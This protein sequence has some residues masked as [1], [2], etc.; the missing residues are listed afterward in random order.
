MFKRYGFAI[1]LILTSISLSQELLIVKDIQIIGLK[2]MT[3]DRILSVLKM[4][5][6]D[7]YTELRLAETVRSDLHRLHKLNLFGLMKVEM[8][9]EDSNIIIKY[10]LEEYPLISEVVYEGNKNLSNKDINK[11]LRVSAGDRLNPVKVQETIN[12]ITDKYIDKGYREAKVESIIEEREAGKAV[13]KFKINEGEKITIHRI[14]IEGNEVISDWDIRTKVLQ[15]KEDRFYNTKTLDQE[16][17]EEDFK[18]IEEAYANKGYLQA[19][20][21]DY[22][23]KDI[24]N[25]HQIDIIIYVHEGKRYKMGE[26]TITG[27]NVIALEEIREMIPLK[28]GDDFSQKKLDEAVQNIVQKYYSKGYIF[29]NIDKIVD[30]DESTGEVRVKVSIDEGSPAKIRQIVITGN[31]TTRD[32]VI[33]REM[34]IYPGNRYRENKVIRSLQRIFNLG[35]FNSINRDILTTQES[36]QVDLVILVEEKPGTAKVNFGAGYS[37]IDGLVGTIDIDWINFDISKLPKFWRCKGAGQRLTFSI[38]IG[39]RT[40]YYNIGFTEPWF[41]GSPV[42]MSI[43]FY[44]TRLDRYTYEEKRLGTSISFGRSLSEYVYGNI[45]Y[46]IE[47]VRVDSDYNVK[48]LPDWIRENLGTNITSSVRLAFERDSRDNTFFATEG[49]DSY[50]SFELA[51][52][53]FGGNINFFKIENATSWYFKTFWKN[54]LAVR[55]S[56]GYVSSYGKTKQ[57]PIFERFYIGGSQTVRGYEDWELGPMDKYGN[58]EGGTVMLYSNLEFRIPIVKNML[59]VLGFWDSGY[60]WKDF[61]SR[62]FKDIQSG[63][64]GGV[65]LDIPMLGLIGFDYGYGLTT[66]SG[67]LHFSIGSTF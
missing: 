23:I 66:H 37:S 15:T 8:D 53:P 3:A 64:G 24:P 11:L 39:K 51:G 58:P 19:K 40:L 10:Y 34:R 12:A 5:V 59:Y 43:N 45:R 41:L 4:K 54:V 31:T 63:I 56:S 67:L 65:R 26:L 6:N 22:E 17:L 44:K 18:R 50:V 27:A 47:K 2:D 25:R 57:V 55:L 9:K 14:V 36:E 13:L 1:I 46:K 30:F 28:R 48:D 38:Q 20:V 33:R 52:G 35:Y 16:V 61:N 7:T 29:A 42:S 62:H 60:A 21:V 32:L 49:S